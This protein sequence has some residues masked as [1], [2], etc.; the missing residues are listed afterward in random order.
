M[1]KQYVII[2]IVIL[3]CISGLSGCFEQGKQNNTTNIED[4]EGPTIPA[5]IRCTT[6][7]TNNKPAFTWNASTDTN[8]VAG[9]YVKIDNGI[10]TWVGN[11]LAWKSTSVITDGI[12]TFYVKAKDGST[13]GNNGS[14]G[15]CSFIIN[16]ST[17]EKPPVADANGPYAGFINRSIIFN[18]SKSDDMDGNIVNYTWNI[19]DGTILY[20]K[21]VTHSYNKSGLYNITLT[22]TDNV[23]LVNTS[24]T[25][26]NIIFYSGDGG[27]SGGS[28]TE[29]EKFIGLWHNIEVEDELW[30]FYANGTRKTVSQEVDEMT[31]QPYLVT[32][33]SLYEVINKKICFR[34]LNAPSDQPSICYDYS[35][36]ENNMLLT[37]SFGGVVVFSLGRD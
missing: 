25:I 34:D 28:P 32:V 16:T 19:G 15:S 23:G 14:Y 9:Y 13:N 21:I 37:V 6:P 30:I 36:S 4:T 33:W 17:G 18:G 22:V 3:L 31:Q 35:F 7:K 11:V 27:D 10:D 5:N 20:G 1:K 8:G 2:T 12:H 26:A 29:Q 24:R